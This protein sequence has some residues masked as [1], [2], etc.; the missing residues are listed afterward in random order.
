[1][2]MA[3]QDFYVNGENESRYVSLAWDAACKLL[4][5]L[6]AEALWIVA[7]DMNKLKRGDIPDA[8]G[9]KNAE[10]FAKGGQF[11]VNGKNAKFYTER[12][13]PRVG[14]NAIVLLIHPTASLMT[15]AD[16][17]PICNALIVVPYFF[18]DVQQWI[19]LNKPTDVLQSMSP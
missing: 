18:K 3:R 19:D 12:T 7:L 9:V 1:M 10:C 4:K 8:I 11:G 15:K 6:L 16:Q 5:E 2:L 17:I 14:E 13:L